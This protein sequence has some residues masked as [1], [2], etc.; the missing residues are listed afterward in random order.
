MR[1][2]SVIISVLVHATAIAVAV[3]AP[4]L[5]SDVLPAIHNTVSP[6]VRAFRP[7]DIPLTVPARR[8]PTPA[9]RSGAPVVAPFGIAPEEPASPSQEGPT[10]PF[11]TE[12]LIT[13]GA[14]PVFG[15]SD[16]VTPIPPPPPPPAPPSV[17][18]PL[19]VGGRIRTPARVAYV[20]PAYPVIAQT[21][22]V[23]GDVV[24]EAIIGVDG[25]VED[26]R[27]VRGI[28]LL[29]DAAL[30]AVSRWRYTPTLLNG[31]PVPVVMTVTV[32]FRLSR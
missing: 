15:N 31:I 26:L 3:I 24:L 32:S 16:S 28:T 11:G 25:T 27:V 13:T 18:K 10:V 8:T 6:Y 14:P 22:R 12:G 20:A 17:T 23:Q 5:A 29:N 7:A 21:A 2:P 30:D 1:S 9:P 4:L 19:R